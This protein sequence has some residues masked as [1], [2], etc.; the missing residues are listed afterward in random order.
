[1]AGRFGKNEEREGFSFPI[2]LRELAL[3]RI[4]A[5]ISR[6]E[7]LHSLITA[8][9]CRKINQLQI[10]VRKGIQGLNGILDYYYPCLGMAVAQWGNPPDPKAVE[11]YK[12]R[13]LKALKRQEKMYKRLL[14]RSKRVNGII[15]SMINSLNTTRGCIRDTVRHDGV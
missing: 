7:Y 1:M 13:Q 10:G 3:R 6:E 4:S 8:A 9:T 14:R 2:G 11:K 15:L 5:M 12:R